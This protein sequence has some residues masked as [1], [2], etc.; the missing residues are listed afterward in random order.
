M[1][2]LRSSDGGRSLV[3][4]TGASQ[5][6]RTPKKPSTRVRIPAAAQGFAMG[7][8]ACFTLLSERPPRIK[9]EL[10]LHSYSLATR[11]DGRAYERYAWGILFAFGILVAVLGLAYIIQGF[12]ASVGASEV[13]VTGGGSPIVYWGI[14]QSLMGATAAVISRTS[15]RKREVGVASA[16]DTA[17]WCGGGSGSCGTQQWELATTSPVVSNPY[18]WSAPTL[19][20]V[21][22]KDVTRPDCKPFRN[23][24]PIYWSE[25]P[26]TALGSKNLLASI[27][28]FDCTRQG[29]THPSIA[30]RVR[31]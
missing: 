25:V 3:V 29:F 20:E 22:P 5:R 18:P 21:L 24:R 8:E 31:M 30:S 16:M 17:R 14:W 4:R 27:G 23:F 2:A 19:Q 7:G 28:S 13:S 10:T 1:F 15:Y 9:Y 6:H 11:V 26:A 12:S